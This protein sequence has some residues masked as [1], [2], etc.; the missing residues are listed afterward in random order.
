MTTILIAKNEFKHF[1]Y[2]WKHLAI[3]GICMRV[4]KVDRHYMKS[5]CAVNIETNSPW[6][7]F[8]LG[9]MIEILKMNER[10]KQTT[11]TSF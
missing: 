3:T 1:K 4:I 9:K 10:I 5:F 8:N 2:A 7:L 11:E 6:V